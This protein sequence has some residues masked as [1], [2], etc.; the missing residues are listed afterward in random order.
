MIDL[1]PVSRR[2][3]RIALVL[4]NLLAAACSNRGDRKASDSATMREEAGEP[5]ARR[6]ASDATLNLLNA[7]RLAAP[8]RAVADSFGAREA[9]SVREET[10]DSASLSASTPIPDIIAAAA[11]VFPRWLMPARTAWYVRFARDRI[12]LAYNDSSRGAATIDSTNWWK[13]LQRRGVRAGR[14]D[15]ASGAAGTR[16]LLV[17]QLAELHYKQAKLAS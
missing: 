9:V 5:A 10:A 3:H 6:L 11:D 17:M 4:A 12:V 7:S 13:V 15:P 1:R 8:L 14:V 2:A 16:A